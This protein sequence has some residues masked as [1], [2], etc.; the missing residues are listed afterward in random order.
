[1]GVQHFFHKVGIYLPNIN[2]F[3]KVQ[4]CLVVERSGIWCLKGE[5]TMESKSREGVIIDHD[6]VVITPLVKFH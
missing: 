2:G 3:Q 1:M 6:V 5:D 4:M